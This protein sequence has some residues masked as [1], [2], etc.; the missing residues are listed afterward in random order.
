[1][2]ILALLPISSSL[3][4]PRI[5]KDIK[6]RQE[7]LTTAIQRTRVVITARKR[8]LGQGNIF[9][10]VC[11]SVHRGE[12]A[13]SMHGCWGACVVA[14]GCA[15][16]WGDASDTTRYGQWA[17]G[18]H[19]TGMHSCSFY[20]RFCLI[21]FVLE[22]ITNFPIFCRA[23]LIRLVGFHFTWRMHFYH[24][25]SKLILNWKIH[26]IPLFKQER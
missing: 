6:V 9:T 18:T 4:K 12:H 2:S 8:S 20:R 26:R 1:M 13:G 25:S 14:E 16:L 3:W 5:S 24:V 23:C 7:L 15:W 19:P 17:G 21:S 11:H 22:K 10:R